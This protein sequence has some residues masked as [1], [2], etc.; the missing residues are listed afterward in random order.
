[1][2]F[3]APENTI[4]PIS[5]PEKKYLESEILSTAPESPPTSQ[6]F[7]V[8]PVSP[9]NEKEEYVPYKSSLYVYI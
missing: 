3:Q 1:M 2:P 9:K 6:N 7:F 4:L 8:D 5:T